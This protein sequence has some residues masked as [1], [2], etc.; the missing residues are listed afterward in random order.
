MCRSGLGHRCDERLT[1][2]Q[3]KK[4]E[5]LFCDP[6]YHFLNAV[7][8]EGESESF[9][10]YYFYVERNY[11]PRFVDLYAFIART[12][13]YTWADYIDIVPGHRQKGDDYPPVIPESVDVEESPAK[14]LDHPIR[15]TVQSELGALTYFFIKS[16]DIL[17]E[18]R[19]DSSVVFFGLVDDDEKMILTLADANGLF[20]KRSTEDRTTEDCLNRTGPIVYPST[21]R[22][23]SSLELPKR[24]GG[25]PETDTRGGS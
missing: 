13:A 11:T 8:F 15:E 24:F 6:T 5:R 7:P 3:R 14:D 22:T 17:I 1:Q 2:E 16:R 18:L 19:D 23:S 9:L 12:A 25:F 4:I 10:H 21:R 20:L